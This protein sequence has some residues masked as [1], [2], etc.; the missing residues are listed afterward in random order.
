MRVLVAFASAHGSTEGIAA[1]IA[2]RLREAGQVVELCPIDEVRSVAGLDGIVLGSA[3]HS[4]A[5]LPPAAAFVEEHAE[6][7]SAQPLWLFSVSSVGDTS[8]VFGRRV[9]NVM[10]R[11]RSEPAQVSAW[12]TRL[13]VRGHRNFAGVVERSHWGL[14]G[15]VFVRAL[16]GTYGDH[17]DWSDVNRWAA[18]IAT[19]LSD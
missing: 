11:A 18:Q 1:A 7:L 5:W 13:D 12:R 8:S 15:T 3:I 16:G 6:Q 9:A 19:E 4:G 14:G 10:R 2:E 17:R